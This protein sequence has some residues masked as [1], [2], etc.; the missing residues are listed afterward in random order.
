[1]CRPYRVRK[2]LNMDWLSFLTLAIFA[3]AL[4]MVL[5]GVFSVIFGS[6]RSRAC[7][8]AMSV[9]GLVVGVVWAYLVGMS[10]IPPFCD[11]DTLEIVY[12]AIID[13]LAIAMGAIVAVAIFLV[14][15]LKS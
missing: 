15:V 7:G 13:V 4:I 14:V 11:V 5:A 8:I 2:E 3:F 12:S 10:D 9:V 1:M 6:G